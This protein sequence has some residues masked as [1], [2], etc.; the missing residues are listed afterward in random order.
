MCN[1]PVELEDGI[2]WSAP[3]SRKRSTSSR[4]RTSPGTPDLLL[5]GK[6][7][8][9][10]RL[11]RGAHPT[12]VESRSIQLWMGRM[13]DDVLFPSVELIDRLRQLAW[14]IADLQ[15]MV[16]NPPESWTAADY[17]R[18]HDRL[19]RRTGQQAAIWEVLRSRLSG[20]HTFRR[21]STP[22]TTD[23]E[24]GWDPFANE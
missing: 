23:E 1:E 21:G 8:S 2:Q 20:S 7:V 13:R 3:A 18:E 24:T 12:D 19:M 5:A 22:P 11:D 15:M 4:G 9:Q 16:N 17:G 6:S 10:E 14:Q